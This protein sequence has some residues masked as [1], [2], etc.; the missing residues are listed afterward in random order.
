MI[1]LKIVLFA[2]A[3][4]STAVLALSIRMVLIKGGKFPETHVSRNAEMKKKGIIC[5]K[6]MDRM[7]QAKVK[8][9]D[10]YKNIR[11]LK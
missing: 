10:K 3:L 7:E 1:T 4:V 5:V 8:R 11:I 6:A 2:I 9:N